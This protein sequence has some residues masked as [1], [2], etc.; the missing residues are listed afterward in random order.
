MAPVDPEASKNFLSQIPEFDMIISGE[1]EVTF[2][3]LAD[4]L[5]KSDPD[6]QSIKGLAFRDNGDIR[7]T[8]Y[9]PLFENL[10]RPGGIERFG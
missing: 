1:T 4:E 8:A 6:L 9:R 2:P 5:G 3:E 10:D 7:L